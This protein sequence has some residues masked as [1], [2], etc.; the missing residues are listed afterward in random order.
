MT[1]AQQARSLPVIVAPRVFLLPDGQRRREF[2]SLFQIAYPDSG[3]SA[4]RWWPATRWR[5]GSVCPGRSFLDCS[6]GHSTDFLCLS[7]ASYTRFG[8]NPSA[9]AVRRIASR[10]EP[11][12]FSVIRPNSRDTSASDVGIG[13]ASSGSAGLSTKTNSPL[14]AVNWPKSWSA[15]PSSHCSNVFVSSRASIIGRL[16]K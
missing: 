7:S 1:G 2:G 10:R 3:V 4:W 13:V 5:S 15:V 11:V 16:P 6:L 14:P 8:A 12:I 9:S